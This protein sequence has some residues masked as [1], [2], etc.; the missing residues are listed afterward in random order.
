VSAKSHRIC[1]TLALGAL[2][3]AIALSCILIGTVV[4]YEKQRYDGLYAACKEAY[5]VN[6]DF[7][8]ETVCQDHDA[9]GRKYERAGLTHCL[10]AQAQMVADAPYACALRRWSQENL[11]GQLAQEGKDAV[12]HLWRTLTGWVS[13]T[14]V[15]PLLIIA[16]Y[17]V[18]RMAPDRTAHGKDEVVECGKPAGSLEKYN[19]LYSTPRYDALP[20]FLAFAPGNYHEN[21]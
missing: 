3:I 2:W 19:N 21:K 12:G 8:F 10:E 18:H 6:R 5:D 4:W 15:W 1:R 11:G 7:T 9:R 16:L 20:P 14:F 17:Y 13:I